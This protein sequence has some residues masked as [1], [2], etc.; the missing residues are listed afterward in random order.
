MEQNPAPPKEIQTNKA[1]EHSCQK[2]KSFAANT[3]HHN[4]RTNI[5][6]KACLPLDRRQAFKFPAGKSCQW[7][8]DLSN[9]ECAFWANLNTG[10]TTETF[11]SFNSL[12][13]SV[14]HF[15]NRS[16]ASAYTFF[17]TNTFVFV[18][19]YFPH[20]NTSKKNKILKNNFTNQN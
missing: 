7:N 6:K 4:H 10:L 18:Y 9:G 15:I 8:L 16:R 17:V 14:Y 5:K 3:T 2:N 20:S 19:E 12:G 13:F 1:P 11:V